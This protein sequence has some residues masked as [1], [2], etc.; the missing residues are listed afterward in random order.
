MVD[1]NGEPKVTVAVDMK[2]NLGNY[3]SASVGLILSQLPAGA[4]EQDIDALLDTGRLAY[5]MMR[6]RLKSKVAET[7]AN[8]GEYR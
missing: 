4:T 1:N 7:R 3:E 6:E 5:D 8:A 2:V